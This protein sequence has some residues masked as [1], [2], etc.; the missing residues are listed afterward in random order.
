MNVLLVEDSPTV[1]QS[2]RTMLHDSGIPDIDLVHVPRLTDALRRIRRERFDAVLFDPGPPDGR[3]F[4]AMRRVQESMQDLAV[5]VFSGHSA[6]QHGTPAERSAANAPQLDIRSD[7]LLLVQTIRRAIER[8]ESER[9]FQHLAFHDGL[10]ALPNRRLLMDRL[11][12]AVARAQR[13]QGLL[14]L[15]Y[16]DLD[17]FKTLNDTLGHAAGDQLLQSIAA[18]VSKQIR[19]SDTLARLGGDEFA[20]LLPELARVEDAGRF[21]SKLRRALEPPFVLGGRSYRASASIGVSLYPN[22]GATPEALL[23]AADAAMY[24]AKRG[25]TRGL[26]YRF[27]SAIGAQSA[28]R[29]WLGGDLKR[30]LDAEELLLHFQPRVRSRTAEVVAVEALLRWKHPTRGMLLPG[31]FLPLAEE[32]N[33]MMPIGARV[34]A[35]ACEQAQAWNSHRTADPIAVSVN[36][37]PKE[38]EHP[39]F[40][41]AVA[42]ALQ[43]SGLPASQLELELSENGLLRD[44][45]ATAATLQRVNELGVRISIDHFGMGQSSLGRLKRLPVHALK[46]DRSFVRDLPTDRT[47]ATIVSAIIAMGHGL[48][49]NVVAEGVETQPQEAELVDRGCDEMQGFYFCAPRTAEELD[50]LFV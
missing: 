13:N 24:Q 1:A 14:A 39:E 43:S 20:I 35:Q 40:P 48:G 37:S 28:D 18:R 19:E 9:Q 25:E 2:V 41:D 34:L 10:T 30:A 16:F 22:D 32:L 46:I 8:K 26:P 7:G 49:L 15:L 42:R 29:L 11:G 47:D 36:L 3:G 6:A 21:A 5:V 27:S 50:G 33:L 17:D 38:F 44:E 31:Q 4:E 23:G 45:A 12:Q